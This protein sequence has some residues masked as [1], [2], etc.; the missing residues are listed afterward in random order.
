MLTNN[1]VH[2]DGLSAPQNISS[3][4]ESSM[5]PVTVRN[6]TVPFRNL[7]EEFFGE[8]AWPEVFSETATRR[9]S[10]ALDLQEDETTYQLQVELPG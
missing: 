5:Y 6:S 7:V 2:H 10:P 4:Q 1:G 8:S 3:F 9:F